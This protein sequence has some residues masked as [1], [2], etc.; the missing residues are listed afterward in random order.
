MKGVDKDQLQPGKQLIFKYIPVALPAG[1]PSPAQD[2]QEEEINL[3]QE[4]QPN[5]A[6]TFIIRIR[7]NSME[8][9]NMPDGCLAVVDRSVKPVSGA[10]IVAVLNGEFTVKRLIITNRHVVLH[11]ENSFYRPMVITPDM[12][13]QVWGVVTHTVVDQRKKV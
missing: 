1:F 4:L 3:S 6:T 13:F 9:A 2:Y 12:D 11:P 7:G 8:G 10:I 5:P